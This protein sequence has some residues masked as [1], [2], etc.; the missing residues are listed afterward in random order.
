MEAALIYSPGDIRIKDVRKPVIREDEMLVRVKAC[1]ICGTDL[2][3]YRIGGP[4]TAGKPVI[5][6]HEF[7]GEIVETGSAVKGLKT[8]DRI[9]GTGLRDC[10]ECYWCQ[11]EKGYC[12]NPK[13]PGEG[14]DGAMAEYVVV[15]RP[16]PDAM[17]FHIPEGMTWQD[18]AVIEPISIS[19]F[20]VEEARIKVGEIAAVLGAGMIGLGIIQALRAAG[21]SKIVVSEP[22]SFRRKKAEKLGADLVL[23]PIETDFFEAVADFTSGQMAGVVFEC[24]G[25]VPAFQQILQVISP[26]GRIMQVGM[27]EKDLVLPPEFTKRMFQFR[28][29]TLRGCGGQRWDKAI[30]HIQAGIIETQ[31]LITHIFQLDAA[32]EA[33]ETQMDAERSIKVLIEI[34]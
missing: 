1:G 24:S 28:N 15:P 19:C 23:D 14:L 8:G 21:A 27:F 18:A 32:K 4:Q 3:Y 7:S 20:A 13:V 29:V 30:E 31:G 6:G 11:S 10:G 12:P 25:S 5:P 34:P 9:V 26:Y 33:F 2:H 22:S 17:V 16:M